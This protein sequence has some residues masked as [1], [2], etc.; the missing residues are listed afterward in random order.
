MAH[1]ASSVPDSFA[2]GS[3]DPFNRRRGITGLLGNKSVLLFQ[4]SESGSIKVD[5][6]KCRARKFAI[7]P[8]RAV[9][10]EYVEHHEFGSGRR[11]S[12]HFTRVW[13]WNCQ[14]RV[15]Q[16]ACVAQGYEARATDTGFRVFILAARPTSG[17]LF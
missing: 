7:G 2:A 10:V 9:F 1:C 17:N 11:L 8:A 3:A 15:V 6:A 16:S 14:M 4:D 12:G 13:A 5:A